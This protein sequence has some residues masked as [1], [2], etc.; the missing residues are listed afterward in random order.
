MQ[1]KA[2]TLTGENRIACAGLEVGHTR[3][4][5][6]GVQS[7]RKT[8]CIILG[9]IPLGKRVFDDFVVKIL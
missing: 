2:P 6:R 7:T 8:R 4:W 1:P 5:S 9:G 3:A